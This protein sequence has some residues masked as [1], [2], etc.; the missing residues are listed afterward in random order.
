MVPPH[1]PAL[2]EATYVPTSSESEQLG[3]MLDFIM[4][5]ERAGKGCMAP[6]YFLAG[7]T[8]GEQVELPSHVYRV[9]RQIVEAM[10]RGLAVTVVPQAHVLTTQQAADLLGVSRPTVIKLLDGGQIPFTRA[11]THRRV[12]LE[13]VLGYRHRRRAEQYAALEATAGDYGDE[14]EPPDA[15]LAACGR[16]VAR[17]RHVATPGADSITGCSSPSW[18]PACCGP[19]CSA[20]SCCR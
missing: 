1:A 5:H 18:T 2:D 4:E 16:R 19:A 15:V 20:T 14:G 11:G 6:R 10:Q 12:R 9:L 13:D 7:A 8:A 17:W 3:V